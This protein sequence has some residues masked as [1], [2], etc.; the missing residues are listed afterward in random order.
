MFL[1]L[2]H[3]YSFDCLK[4]SIRCRKT[5]EENLPSQLP[6]ALL[7]LSRWNDSNVDHLLVLELQNYN[8]E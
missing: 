6:I 5:F 3:F 1:V 7:L 2:N 4:I 8:V